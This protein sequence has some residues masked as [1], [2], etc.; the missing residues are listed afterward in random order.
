MAER[1][2]LPARRELLGTLAALPLAAAPAAAAG[3][4]DPHLA[5]LEEYHVLAARLEEEAWSGQDDPGGWDDVG[6][7]EDRILD[8]RPNT[9]AGVAAQ[10]MVIVGAMHRGS[11]FGDQLTSPVLARAAELLPAPGFV[12]ILAGSA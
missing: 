3:P 9:V 4:V 5:W 11:C 7:I 8:T 12:D 6:E 1:M 2:T 10:M